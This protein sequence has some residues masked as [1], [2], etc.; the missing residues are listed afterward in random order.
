MTSPRAAD[1]VLRIWN[2]E[3]M[4]NLDG[5]LETILAELE[6]GDTPHPDR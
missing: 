4:T 3:T 2:N 5:V 1:C 6:G